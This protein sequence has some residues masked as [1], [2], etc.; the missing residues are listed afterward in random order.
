MRR[1]TFILIIS[2][3][4]T[5]TSTAYAADPLVLSNSEMQK[6]QHY[7]PAQDDG[8]HL[9]WKGDPLSI[10][11]PLNQEKRIVFP[12]KVLPDLKG[13]LSTDQLRIINDDK[14]LYLTALKPFST[15]R[16]FVT[17]QDTGEV[18][19]IDLAT[20]DKASQTTTYIDIKQNNSSTPAVTTNTITNANSASAVD[21]DIENSTSDGDTYITLMRYAWQQLYAPKRLLSNPLGIS[22]APMH[23][24]NMLATL[25]Y[26]DKVYAHPAVSWVY[27]DTYIT[28][29][30]LRNKYPH[31]TSIN[32]NRDLCGNWQAAALY[33]RTTLKPDGNK[34]ADSTVLFLIS[35][36]PFGDSMEV[37]NGHA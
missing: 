17:L 13:A 19:M 11:L 26:G 27:N 37:C 16:I 33:P 36:K 30:E 1:K 28:A 21:A 3:L 14:S 2:S 31:T 5:L 7:F 10:A 29:V 23:T 32:I 25:V 24:D 20:D 9:V 4:L 18:L 34:N 8:T 12:S 15:T 35:K 6:L 22:R